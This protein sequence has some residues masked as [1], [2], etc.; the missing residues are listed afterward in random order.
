[1]DELVLKKGD[2]VGFEQRYCAIIDRNI[3]YAS[4]LKHRSQLIVTKLLTLA[5]IHSDDKYVVMIRTQLSELGDK[6][7][8]KEIELIL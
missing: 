2:A 7:Y 8:T 5:R 3:F 4:D 1:M 6:K